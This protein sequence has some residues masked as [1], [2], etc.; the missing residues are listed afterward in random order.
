[1]ADFARG[2][3]GSANAA[4]FLLTSFWFL[5]LCVV[6]MQSRRWR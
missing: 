4:F 5:A 3:I 2:L 1:M 6:L